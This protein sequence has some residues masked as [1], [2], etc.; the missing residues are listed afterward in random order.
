[1]THCG[2]FW[3]PE[4]ALWQDTTFLRSNTQASLGFILT[5]NSICPG[6]C[7]NLLICSVF[8]TNPRAKYNNFSGISLCTRPFLSAFK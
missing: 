7:D 4:A 1:M 3:S 8:I 5:E 2:S 6:I